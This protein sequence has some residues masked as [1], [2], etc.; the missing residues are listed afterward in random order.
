V[1]VS[2]RLAWNSIIAW[3]SSLAGAAGGFV[4]VAYLVRRLGVVDYGVVELLD[5]L[6]VFAM[7]SDL[8][9]RGALGRHLT[10]HIARGDQRRVNELLTVSALCYLAIAAG[11][12]LI[13]WFFAPLLARG[14]RITGSQQE[15]AIWLVRL[16]VPAYTLTMFVGTSFTAV[17]ESH[18]RFDIVDLAH[19]AEVALRLLLIYLAISLAGWGVAGWAAGYLLAKLLSTV[20]YAAY[21]WRLSPGIRIG[22]GSLD[23]SSAGELFSLGTLMLVYQAVMKLSAQTDPFILSGYLGPAAVG[24]YR[25]AFRVVMAASPFVAVVNRQLRPLATSYFVRQEHERLRELLVRGT[26]ISLL[27]SLPFAVVFFC[28]AQPLVELWLGGSQ[29]DVTAWVLVLWTLAELAANAAGAQFQ[30]LLGMNRIRFIVAVQSVAA[31]L[32][33]GASIAVVGLLAAWGWGTNACLLAVVV[34]TIVTAWLQRALVSVRVAREVEIGVRRYLKQGFLPAGLVGALLL[35]TGLAVRSMIWLDTW[36]RFLAASAA[37][38]AAW[39]VL[40]W[41]LGFDDVD[42]RRFRRVVSLRRAPPNGDDFSLS[43]LPDHDA[44]QPVEHN[45]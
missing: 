6:V 26:K 30:I 38:G 9:I 5:G 36:P 18:H 8:G 10:E 7:L 42:R 15:A 28:F 43:A 20:V 27:L 35:A 19:T 21:A 22:S 23:W 12:M 45:P 34:P 44:A 2:A 24:L 13:C 31:V 4:L 1:N 40:T 3:L 33:V 39:L 37:I 11:L 29:F 14:L 41:L 16:F 25:P 32:N 17:I